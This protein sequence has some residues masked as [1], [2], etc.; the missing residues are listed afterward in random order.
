M[1]P[2]GPKIAPRWPVLRCQQ[3]RQG[4]PR[5]PKTAREA[6]KRKPPG[7]PQYPKRPESLM[8][9]WLFQDCGMCFCRPSDATA[10]D[11]PRRPQDQPVMAPEASR[12]SP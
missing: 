3:V 4:D 1:A 2:R 11:G 5:M 10:R 9:H 6:P 12:M 8:F 7:G